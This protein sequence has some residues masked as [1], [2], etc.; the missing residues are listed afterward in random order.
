[1][2]RCC[3]RKIYNCFT[4]ICDKIRGVDFFV[5]VLQNEENHSRYSAT[6]ASRF[7][8]F[9]DYFSKLDVSQ[10]SIIDIGC[11]KGRMLEYWSKYRFKNVDGVEYSAQLC[12]I[13]EKN[14]EVLRLPCTVYNE[15]AS[16]FS[17]YIDYDFFYMFNPIRGELF[18]RVI[19]KIEESVHIKPR[20]VRIIYCNPWEESVLLAKG[21]VCERK[22]E[23]NVNIYSNNMNT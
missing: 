15:D 17:R 6:P 7:T 11:G 19:E 14:M 12:R 23:C 8:A 3:I 20:K 13:C 2:I 9:R 16:M 1:M 5:E 10:S 4:L 22:Y 18:E 21:W